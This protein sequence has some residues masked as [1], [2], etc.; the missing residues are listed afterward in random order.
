MQI[1]ATHG[2]SA[3]LLMTLG[4]L[5]LGCS[6]GHGQLAGANAGG[7]GADAGTEV[8]GGAGGSAG[9]EGG[10]APTCVVADP[11]TLPGRI[12]APN[13]LISLGRPVAASSGV[14]NQNQLVDGLHNSSAVS[15]GVPTESAP[16]W[17]AID[18]GTGPSRVLLI[19]RDAGT[20]AYTNALGGAP[21]D[22]HLDTSA[23][24]T[25]GTNGTWTTVATVPANPVHVREHAFDFSG[26]RWVKLVVTAA[27]PPLPPPDGGT[28]GVVYDVR[29]DEISV[30][31]LSAADGGSPADT[32][33]FMGDSITQGAFAGNYGA[34]TRFDDLL[35]TAMPAYYPAMVPGGITSEFA[36]DA[37]RHINQDHF[38]DL[39]PDLTHV[40]IGYGTNDSWGNKNPV[41]VGFE[42]TMDAVVSA[43]IAAGRVPI[44]ARIPY[45]CE[46]DTATKHTTIPR[47]NEIIDRLQAKYNLP[48]GPDLY[49]YFA[50]H[51]DQLADCVHP[52]SAGYKVMNQLWADAARVLYPAN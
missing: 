14:T 46:P 43:V 35:H 31:D 18:L 38:L 44:L 37:L 41:T 1:I 39:N 30:F 22:Y 24:S 23:D 6:T 10:A 33:F 47:F 16:A 40:A 7:G 8:P 26:Q 29:L 2:Q 17:A 49:S 48:C 13:P 19:W 27:Q 25:D 20:V 9:G 45:A 15:F 50:A 5:A 51:P 42:A 21:Y 4:G 12:Q 28:V 34:G 11:S 52:N 36:T 3:I 32:W